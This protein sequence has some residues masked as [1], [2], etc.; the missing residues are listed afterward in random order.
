MTTK[1]P[2]H[3]DCTPQQLNDATNKERI[4]EC[5]TVS[6][7]YDFGA[8]SY[9]NDKCGIAESCGTWRKKGDVLL[10]GCIRSDFCGT[11]AEYEG[12]G[13]TYNCPQGAKAL[14]KQ[15]TTT[16]PVPA[17]VSDR[18]VSPS[19]PAAAGPDAMG[20]TPMFDLFGYSD[21]DIVDGAAGLASG[22]MKSDERA[23]FSNCYGGIPQII[24]QTMVEFESI[25]WTDLLDWSKDW[26]EI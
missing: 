1:Q 26:E 4:H 14:A 5:S 12:Y 2:S 17:G 13:T 11:E 18:P 9:S 16:E 25:D 19:D 3:T 20:R 7:C 21:L 24:N 8:H 22:L 6:S 10:Q 23:H 15:N